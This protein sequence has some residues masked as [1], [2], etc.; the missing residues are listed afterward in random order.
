MGLFDRFRKKDQEPSAP[1]LPVI[2]DVAFGRTVTIDRLALSMLGAHHRSELPTPSLTITG[3]GCVEFEDGVFLHRFYTDDHVLLQ[4]LGGDGKHDKSVQQISVFSVYDSIEP[5]SSTSL[6][7]ELDRI[8]QDHYVLDGE[9]Y[10]RV[11]FDGSG[12]TAPVQ[13][14]EDVYLDDQGSES[15]GIQQSCMLFSRSVD[16]VDEMLLV[17]HEKTTEG[18]ESITQMVGFV[19]SPND[20]TL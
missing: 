3:Q 6:K 19:L 18:G 16:D 8:G 10:D 1:R 15:Y 2:H 17:T 14:F 5:A 9:R 4:I 13:F 7:A 12:P 11:W 20:L